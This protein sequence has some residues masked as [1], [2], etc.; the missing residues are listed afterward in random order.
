MVCTLLEYW[1]VTHSGLLKFQLLMISA[2]ILYSSTFTI[3]IPQLLKRLA[4]GR[5]YLA[6]VFRNCFNS[7]PQEKSFL[8]TLWEK[9]KML[10]T[11]IF[12]FSHS[13][14]YP[15][16]DRNHHLSYSFFLSSANA[17][18]LVTCKILLFGKQLT[19]NPFSR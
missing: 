7:L 8:K 11:S 17:F 9:E 14:F 12:S 1:E 2:A 10:V 6:T 16:S 4:V 5:A 18:N 15:V 3:I 19:R 13:V